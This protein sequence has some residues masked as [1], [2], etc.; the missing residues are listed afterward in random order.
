MIVKPQLFHSPV[1]LIKGVLALR[2][3]VEERER[4]GLFH[5]PIRSPTVKAIAI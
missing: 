3:E 1:V 2:G 5:F 4:A